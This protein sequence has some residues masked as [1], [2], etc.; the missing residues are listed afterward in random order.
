MGVANNGALATTALFF[1]GGNSSKGRHP[2]GPPPRPEEDTMGNNNSFDGIDSYATQLIQYKARHLIGSYGFTAS[3]REDIEQELIL[4]LLQR[5]P[6]YNPDRAKR[7]TFIA[8]IIDNQIASMIKYRTAQKRDYHLCRCSLNDCRNDEDD[9]SV[10]LLDT[11]DQ[12]DY[13][14]RIGRERLS[15]IDQSDIAIDVQR[16]LAGLSPELRDLCEHLMKDKTIRDIAKSTGI[17]RW[18]IYELI[19]KL[20]V[21]FQ[22]VI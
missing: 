13:F 18:K 3:D 11:I 1:F 20:R 12:D 7:T 17:P 10:E 4:D 9:E 15:T 21:L 8:R 2:R 22:D 6:K 14:R 19:N 5:L 16:I